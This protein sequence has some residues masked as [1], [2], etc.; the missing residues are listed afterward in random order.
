MRK[1]KIKPT[2]DACIER[3]SYSASIV[4]SD[5]CYLAG[6]TGAVSAVQESRNTIEQLCK[7]VVAI[8]LWRGVAVVV[9]D[10]V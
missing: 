5:S 4:T 3:Y 7:L 8:V 9:I 6:A 10:I 2:A 1:R